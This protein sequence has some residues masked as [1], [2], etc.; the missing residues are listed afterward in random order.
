M[1]FCSWLLCE[2]RFSLWMRVTISNKNVYGHFSSFLDVKQ[3]TVLIAIL[4]EAQIATWLNLGEGETL[5]SAFSQDVLIGSSLSRG[6]RSQK[7]SKAI[8]GHRQTGP[9]FS[10]KR[11][12]RR[13]RAAIDD[14]LARQPRHWLVAAV[15]LPV[16]ASL[17]RF[18]PNSRC[19]SALHRRYKN[20]W[21][22]K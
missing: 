2:S 10:R 6:I 14:I 17:A 11:K 22:A 20:K 16:D 7:A 19:S 5:R 21:L 13:D 4:W 1:A 12:K 9:I 8:K 3:Q 15:V 18:E